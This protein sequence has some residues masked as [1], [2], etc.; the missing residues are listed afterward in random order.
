VVSWEYIFC[1][2]YYFSTF[3]QGR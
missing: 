1:Y 2:K 3:Y